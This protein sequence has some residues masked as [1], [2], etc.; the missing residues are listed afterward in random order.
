MPDLRKRIPDLD[1]TFRKSQD[2]NLAYVQTGFGSPI[3]TP[4]YQ[5]SPPQAPLP[6]M[7]G[8]LMQQNYLPQTATR[9]YSAI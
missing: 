4:T 7:N 6:P 5:S 9:Y 3:S 8:Q 1:L 2:N